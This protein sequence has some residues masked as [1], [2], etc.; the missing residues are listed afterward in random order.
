[1]RK[2]LSI[3]VLV[4]AVLVA[5][6]AIA[7]VGTLTF[8]ADVSGPAIF[9]GNKIVPNSDFYINIYTNNVGG[10]EPRGGMSIPL[11][12]SFVNSTHKVVWGDSSLFPQPQFKS[13]WNVFQTE[14]VESWDGNLP[15][16]FNFTGVADV[17]TGGGY[18]GNLGEILAFRIALK[19]S[20]PGNN[21]GQ[22]CIEQGDAVNDIYDWIFED[23]QP[24][25]AKTCWTIGLPPCGYSPQMDSCEPIIPALILQPATFQ[26][27]AIPRATPNIIVY[28]II[29]GP[30][31]IDPITGVWSYT[32]TV[33]DAWKQLSLVVRARDESYYC[34]GCTDGLEYC[35]TLVAVQGV[36]GDCDISGLVNISDITRM[37]NC[38]YYY[39]SRCPSG[40]T[41][42][43]DANGNGVTNIQ[44]ITYLI[45]YLYKGGQP[46]V[47]GPW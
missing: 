6:E 26:F 5:G 10:T 14:Y 38:L 7:Q 39:P 30:G 8:R 27:H 47:C 25:F 4:L 40:M 19:L 46:P 36:C 15:D 16:L 20:C 31:T 1:M 45:N 22:F 2:L 28:E 35:S 24:T 21:S 44:D 9:S 34:H 3:S 41:P 43:C 17:G 18:P 33:S 11:S 12:L 42:A 23:P 37:I 13:F 29:S 32:P